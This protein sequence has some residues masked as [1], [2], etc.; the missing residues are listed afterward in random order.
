MQKRE[1][2]E[3]LAETDHVAELARLLCGFHGR[4]T[5]RLGRVELIELANQTAG[6]SYRY[7]YPEPALEAALTIGLVRTEGQ[8]I[9]LAETGALFLRLKTGRTLELNFQQSLLLLG[10]FLDDSHMFEHI[11]ILMK[12][13]RQG[14]SGRLEAKTI[15][16]LWSEQT[17]VTAKI[18]QQL[19]ILDDSTDRLCIN[20]TFEPFLPKRL[21]MRSSLTEEGL[22]KRLEAQRLR[23]R[24]AE[25]LVMLEERKRL[26]ELG[27]PDL[28]EL[29]VRI[30]AE[31]VVAGYDIESFE[32]DGSPRFIE[33]KSSIGEA[34]RFEW[35]LKEREL[36]S[37]LGRT[38]WVYFVPLSSIL[39]E[40]KVPIYML[41]D[42]DR[43][44]QMGRLAEMASSYFV[45]AKSHDTQHR[46]NGISLL[47]MWS[48]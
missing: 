23:A 16:H 27:R 39:Q 22:W 20:P 26:E 10:L 9:S 29:V 46:R 19:G 30:S 3:L 47:V 4:K 41:R 35:S 33:V 12:Q 32:E 13:F 17:R 24:E 34:V 31:D 37:E 48:S 40:R 38:Y 14:T 18:F 43:L 6:A 1:L 25:T 28:A 21:L 15:P 5:T 36:A 2:L 8:L 44:I 42:P 11:T 45:C 7:P